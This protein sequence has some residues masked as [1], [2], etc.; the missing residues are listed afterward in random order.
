[1]DVNRIKSYFRYLHFVI[2]Y[3]KFFW[4][5]KRTEDLFVNFRKNSINEKIDELAKNEH[6]KTFLDQKLD[7]IKNDDNMTIEEK[8]KTFIKEQWKAE[9]EIIKENLDGEIRVNP[10][11]NLEFDFYKDEN[12]SEN[13]SEDSKENNDDNTGVSKNLFSFLNL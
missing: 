6:L 12:E 5:A 3:L 9:N 8:A 11:G 1:M 4:I 7:K 10:Y 2:F 13:A